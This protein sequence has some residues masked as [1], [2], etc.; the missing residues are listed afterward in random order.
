MKNQRIETQNKK[1]LW[2]TAVKTS[3]DMFLN[4]GGYPE[5]PFNLSNSTS[6]FIFKYGPYQEEEDYEFLGFSELPESMAQI[7][8][9]EVRIELDYNMMIILEELGNL[10]DLVLPSGSK[11]SEGFAIQFKDEWKRNFSDGY[12]TIYLTLRDNLSWDLLSY[13]NLSFTEDGILNF[14]KSSM[15]SFTRGLAGNNS[16]LAKRV[17]N[18]GEIEIPLVESYMWGFS[19]TGNNQDNKISRLMLT[20]STLE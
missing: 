17:S 18:N 2:D 11:Y 5:Y 10:T 19:Y 6:E 13:T 3:T 9:F 16:I 15:T 7:K 8:D 12:Y 4:K 20:I 1:K 14:S